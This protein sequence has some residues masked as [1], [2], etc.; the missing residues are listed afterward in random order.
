MGEIEDVLGHGGA[1]DDAA[2]LNCA[3]FLDELADRVEEGGG[4]LDVKLVIISLSLVEGAQ[5]AE[6]GDNSLTSEYHRY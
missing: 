2:D 5:V 3:F 1:L 6:Y 4:E